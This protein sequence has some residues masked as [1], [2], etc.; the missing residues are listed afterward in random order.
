MKGALGPEARE[1]AA[2]EHLLPRARLTLGAGGDAIDNSRG[3][4]ILD[5][6]GRLELLMGVRVRPL[7]AD[8]MVELERGLHRAASSAAQLAA[9]L[10]S[11]GFQVRELVVRER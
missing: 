3:F 10:E 1:S 2:G 5:G 7:T 6:E 8:D 4:V 9:L 11:A